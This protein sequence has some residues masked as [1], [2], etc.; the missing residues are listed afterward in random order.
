MIEG[1][2]EQTVT[3][4][5]QFPVRWKCGS[6]FEICVRI[7]AEGQILSIRGLSS[8]ELECCKRVN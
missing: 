7:L 6:N 8:S 3:F 1:L 2:V 4:K 5:Y